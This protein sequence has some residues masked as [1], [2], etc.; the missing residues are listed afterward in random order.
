MNL[1]DIRSLFAEGT[2]IYLVRDIWSEDEETIIGTEKLKIDNVNLLWGCDG[3]PEI[4]VYSGSIDVVSKDCVW[5]KT[6]MPVEMLRAWK[7]YAA[8]VAENNL[9]SC[10]INPELIGKMTEDE[11]IQAYAINDSKEF[12]DNIHNLMRKYDVH[13]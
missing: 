5:I 8:K 9:L 12:T 1:S 4:P 7:S 11:I 2:E 6:L 13:A 10:E 3:F